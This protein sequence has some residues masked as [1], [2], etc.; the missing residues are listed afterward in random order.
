MHSGN[1][2]VD[3]ENI[4]VQIHT[5]ILPFL[6]SSSAK[7]TQSVRDDANHGHKIQIFPKKMAF[8]IFFGCFSNVAWLFANTSYITYPKVS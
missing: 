1:P 3:Y 6:T 2:C 8:F 5:V 7:P 4:L